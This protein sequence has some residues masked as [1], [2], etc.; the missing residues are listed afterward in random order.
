MVFDQEPM[1]SVCQIRG[2]RVQATQVQ[3]IKQF[4]MSL[5]NGQSGGMRILGLIS[6]LQQ[7]DFFR[8]FGHRQC[9][10]CPGHWGFLPEGLQVSHVALYHHDCFLTA[11]PQLGV[12]ALYSEAMW[13]RAIFSSQGLYHDI[14][15]FSS[16]GPSHLHRY[17]AGGE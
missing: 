5:P 7:L 11:L 14:D 12:H 1:G 6:P 17:D 2:P 3:F 16:I 15:P 9:C 10:Y 13:Q 8:G 4:T